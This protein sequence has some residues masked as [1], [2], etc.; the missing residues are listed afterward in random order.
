MLKKVGS[1]LLHNLVAYLAL[2][3][4]LSGTA[5]AAAKFTGSDIA[6]ESLTGADI[7]NGSLTGA[8]TGIAAAF[9]SNNADDPLPHVAE[10]LTSANIT[11]ARESTLV[12]FGHSDGLVVCAQPAPDSTLCQVNVGL[13]LDG[14]PI[15]ASAGESA[16][17]FPSDGKSFEELTLFAT[18][19]HVSAGVHAVSIAVGTADGDSVLVGFKGERVAAI[20]IPE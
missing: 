20:A 9:G 11:V 18:V 8:D 14:N 5:Y 7:L 3:L 1:H 16:G 2:F 4:A 15:P 10:V 19:P 6:D 12:V 13:F 17:L